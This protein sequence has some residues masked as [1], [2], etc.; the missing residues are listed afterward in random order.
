MR[1]TRN[2]AKFYKGY[3]AIGNKYFRYYL[4]CIAE[5][6]TATGQLAI[7]YIAKSIND[8][9]NKEFETTGFEYV[10]YIDTDSVTGDT[11]LTTPDG[12]VSIAEFYDTYCGKVLQQSKDNYTVLP[13]KDVSVLS[14]DEKSGKAVQKKVVNMKKHLVKKQ[15]F[16]LTVGGKSVVVTQDHSLVVMRNGVLVEVKPHEVRPDDNFVLENGITN[17]YIIEPLGE[18]EEWVYDIEVE[19]THT[20]FA[21]DILVHNSNYFTLENF[22]L[23]RVPP[24]TDVN[25]IVTMIDE[26][27]NDVVEPFIA[28]KYQELSDYL[29]AK[30]NKLIMKREAIAD[31]MILRGKKNYII[32]VYDNEHVRYSEPKLKMMGIET[33]RT[34]TPKIVREELKECLKLI[35]KNDKESL[36]KRVNS[37]KQTYYSSTIQTIAFPRG[38]KDIEKW[39]CP[40]TGTIISGCPIHVRAALN[41]NHLI[42]SRGVT[43]YYET[44]TSGDK[45]RFI[46]LKKGNSIGSHVLGFVDDVPF[47]DEIEPFVDRTTLF[48]NSFLKPLESFS[49]LVNMDIRNAYSI[50]D[51]FGSGEVGQTTTLAACT[52]YVPPEEKKVQQRKKQADTGGLM[53]LFT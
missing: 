47:A 37:F 40:L 46:L 50:G 51:L 33:A 17:S 29:N 5:G 3:G 19:D 44:I 28:A 20:F 27:V 43:N 53:A 1:R 11:V 35:V 24:N 8:M 31:C 39:V 30:E 26:Y 12:K 45:M 18:C 41:Y 10:I 4:E 14:Y 36:R 7:R 21:N 15:M 49:D 48:E 52:N 42:K 2:T 9:L 13:N 23:Q 25:T 32:N 6:I 22:V 38:V 16:K 34:S